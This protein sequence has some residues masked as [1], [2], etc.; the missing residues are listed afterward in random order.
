MKVNSGFTI[1]ELMVVVAV[2]AVIATFAIPG[3]RVFLAN[4]NIRGTA[5]E[6]RSGMEL[7]RSEALRRK[8]GHR[9]C[10]RWQQLE[11]IRSGR[12]RRWL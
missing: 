9:F 4:A 12:Q 8:C 6:I 3:M 7:A 5:E 11:S 1:V 10:Y 2:V